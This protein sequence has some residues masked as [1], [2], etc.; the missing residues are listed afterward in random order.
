VR[1]SAPMTPAALREQLLAIPDVEVPA[2]R[3]GL[4]ESVA[5]LE[6][7]A[8]L[9]R[10][11]EDA[12][13]PKWH[14]PWWHMLLLLELGEARRIP[15][16]TVR[17]MVAAL[18]ALPLHTFPLGPE[19]WPA[20][21]EPARHAS[22]HCAL[23]SVD[24][25]LTACGVDVDAELPWIRS[26]FERYQMRD[27]GLNCDEGAYRV[28]DEC[29]SSMVG[30]IAPF[31]AMRRRGP[32]PF[33]ERAAG[34]LIGRAL[35][36]GSDTHHNAEEREAAAAW[37]APTFPRFYFYDVLRGATAL[38]SWA[39][40]HGRAL[41]LAAIAPAAAHLAATAPDGTVR[42]R[43][44]AFARAGSWVRGADGA[45]ARVPQAA[46]FPLLE[47]VSRLGA[48]SAALTREWRATRHALVALVDAGQ[49][50]GGAA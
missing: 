36:H 43:R 7:D 48:P 31:E 41:P 23:G 28:A 9:E 6:S 20:G 8:A 13:W 49:V 45:W 24:R 25:V 1:P 40:E 18:D 2:E 19:D 37:R 21:L 3:A 5:Y 10:L 47:A 32:G 26:W 22:C 34:F 42:I 30:T 27:G 4:D 35:V 39:T 14:A 46:S 29:P 50:T 38:V 16:R 12:Y 17:A 15:A 33:V 44:R 11:A